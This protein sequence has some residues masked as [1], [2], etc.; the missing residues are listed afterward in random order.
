MVLKSLKIDLD[1]IFYLGLSFNT[2]LNLNFFYLICILFSCW[3]RSQFYGHTI[4]LI[5]FVSADII[6]NRVIF[7]LKTQPNY[8][9]TENAPSKKNVQKMYIMWMKSAQL[10]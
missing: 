6:E 4:N 2:N 1:Q 7:L 10:S 3:N 9:P 8:K 5:F